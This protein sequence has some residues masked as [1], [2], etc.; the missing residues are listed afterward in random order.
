VLQVPTSLAGLL[1]LLA[2][3]FTQPTFQTFSMLVVGFVGRVRDCTVTGMLQ[4]CGLAGVWHHSRAHDLF[5]RRRWDPDQLG[6]ALLDFLVTVF[7]KAGAPI[8]L[9]VDDTLFGRSGR[10]V[11][12]AHY[13]H[14]G[15][16]PE[17]S[18]R[19]TRWGNCWVV[20]VLVV[21]LR[22][23]GGRQVGLPVLFRLFR[24][25]DDDHPHRPSQ[26]QLAR[27]LVDMVIKRFPGR[28]VELVMDGAYA[29]KAWRNLPARVTVTTR[30]R[31]NARVHELAPSA[32]TPGQKGRPP[33][34]GR[35]LPTLG[36]IAKT[37]VFQAVTITGPDGRSRTAHVHEFVCL[38]YKPFYTRP[39]KVILIRNPG[40]SDGFDVALASTDAELPAGELIARYDS[41]WTIE[42]ANQEAKAHGVGEARNRVKQAVERTVPF[43]FLCQT[44][45]IA[46]YAV[47]G[48]PE[49]DLDQRLRESPWYRQKTTISYA[50]M[51]AALRRE[52]IRHEFWAQAPPITT[53]P[54]LTQPQSPSASKAA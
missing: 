38:W 54:K 46:W 42:T 36:E 32:R 47:H 43:G 50:D 21:E 11:F 52:L 23:L 24:P 22:C 35:K 31:G 25:K 19:R 12:G 51:L 14:D 28:M 4:A 10:K 33:L 48:D 20:V 16:Q 6:L 8:R 17:G 34:K 40:T 7:V 29:S 9:A 39:V 13:L 30:M 2:P 49:T 41:R 1:S 18:G 27:L 5:A 44:I 37:A 3:C 26:P 45:T 53:N 15:A